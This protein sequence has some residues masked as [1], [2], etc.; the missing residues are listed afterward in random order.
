MPKIV[1]V[2]VKDVAHWFTKLPAFPSGHS[3]E[4]DPAITWLVGENGC[5]KSSLLN[6]INTYEKMRDKTPIV[7]ETVGERGSLFFFDTEKMNPRVRHGLANEAEAL[8]F[9]VA[10]ILSKASHGQTLFPILMAATKEHNF[11]NAVALVDEPESGVSPWNQKKLLDAWVKAT[12]ERGT[13]FVIAT[14][15]PIFI[16]SGIGSVLDMN[17]HP[18]R[19]VSTAEY[20]LFP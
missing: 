8:K 1:R 10:T 3:F 17:T 7:V 4:F 19:C 11:E 2:T 16:Q 13:Q 18:A 20:T 12:A 15:S 14:H 9:Q 5:G 6:L